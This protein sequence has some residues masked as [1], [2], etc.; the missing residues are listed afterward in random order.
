[1]LRLGRAAF[2]AP[3][4]ISAE[5]APSYTLTSSPKLL[6]FTPFET[7]V[8]AS[9]QRSLLHAVIF[10]GSPRVVFAQLP[11]RSF[12]GNPVAGS[13][14]FSEIRTS[15]THLPKPTKR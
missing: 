9:L 6:H 3:E 12:P 1:M 13:N 8:L 5:G 14:V 10:S 7:A 4:G 2:F 11:G 15:E